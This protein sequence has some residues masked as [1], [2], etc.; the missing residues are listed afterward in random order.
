[1]GYLSKHA[2]TKKSCIWRWLELCYCAEIEIS[3]SIF[4]C[5]R[6]GVSTL[7]LPPTHL[8]AT[9]CCRPQH[10]WAAANPSPAQSTVPYAGNND[11]P[12]IQMWS[13]KVHTY[14][15]TRYMKTPSLLHSDKQTDTH[16]F[17]F[18]ALWYS[19]AL[20]LTQ[21]NIPLHSHPLRARS[22]F[23]LNFAWLLIWDADGTPACCPAPSAH[24]W[25]VKRIIHCFHH[26][27]E[28]F[29]H[30]EQLPSHS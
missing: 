22:V 13:L 20:F 29:E 2:T 23:S 7:C 19:E 25:G 1:M 27:T 6:S 3:Y 9:I 8:T 30:K 14:V 16:L 24:I 18:F 5:C 11:K 26:T 15:L 4:T 28:V 12:L 21:T 17:F 10:I